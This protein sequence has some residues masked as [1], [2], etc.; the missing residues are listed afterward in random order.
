MEER[1]RLAGVAPGAAGRSARGPG[2]AAGLAGRRPSGRKRHRAGSA[3]AGPGGHCGVL[4]AGSCSADALAIASWPG[5]Q[6]A[7][8][9]PQHARTRLA[10]EVFVEVIDHVPAVALLAYRAGDRPRVVMAQSYFTGLEGRHPVSGA[11]CLAR[12]AHVV[13]VVCNQEVVLVARVRHDRAPY[14]SR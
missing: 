5:G 7:C 8:A 14:S 6:D 10:P 4:A 12:V 2:R 9:G 13:V 1:C 11:L 3:P